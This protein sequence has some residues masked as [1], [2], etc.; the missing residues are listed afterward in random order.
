MPS[1]DQRPISRVPLSLAP[2]P[3]PWCWHERRFRERLMEQ[4]K[5]KAPTMLCALPRQQDLFRL[6]A[7]TL[8]E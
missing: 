2:K 7:S 5:C 1:Q 8:V 6:L 4:Q 3:A